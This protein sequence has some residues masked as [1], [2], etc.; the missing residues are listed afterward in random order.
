MIRYDQPESARIRYK[1]SNLSV[2]ARINHGK[3]QQNQTIRKH[4]SKEPRQRRGGA[5][6]LRPPR[7]MSHAVWSYP[8][9]PQ[10]T[11]SD[12]H[13]LDVKLIWNFSSSA[14]L[15]ADS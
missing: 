5:K 4:A 7:I 2:K 6:P 8:L 15:G 12:W 13:W 11:T 14:Q 1:S 10:N 9:T 3:D